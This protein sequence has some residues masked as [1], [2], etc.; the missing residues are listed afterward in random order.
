MAAGHLH[1][2]LRIDPTTVMIDET[3]KQLWTRVQGRINLQEDC[4]MRSSHFTRAIILKIGLL[5]TWFNGG[6]RNDTYGYNKFDPVCYVSMLSDN[7]FI[8]C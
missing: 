1:R 6:S 3:I 2:L 4:T 8:L 5:T 7:A